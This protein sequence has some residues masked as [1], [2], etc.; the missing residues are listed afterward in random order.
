MGREIKLAESW[1]EATAQRHHYDELQGRLAAD[2]CVIGGG[3][4]GLTTALEC[5]RRGLTTVL[6]EAGRVAGGASG[7]NG[8]FVSNGFAL[9]VEGLIGAVGLAAAKELYTLSRL[10][11]EYVRGTIAAH[12]PAIQMGCGGRVALRHRDTGGLRSYRDLLNG[13]FGEEHQYLSPD[14]TRQFLASTRYFE[15]LASDG[16]FHIHTLHYGIL[17]ARLAQ[18]AG[19]QVFENTSALSCVKEG[20]NFRVTTAT[21]DVYAGQVVH[22][23]SALDSRLHSPS[24]RAVLPVATYVAVTEPLRQ[25][26]IR[27]SSAISDT[28]RAGDYYRLIDEGRILWGGRITTR[29]SEPRHLAEHMKADMLSVYPAL[30]NPRV[31]YAWAGLM[32]YAIHKMPL[33]GRDAEG[34]WFATA[35]GGHGLNTTAMAGVLVARGIS[36]ADDEWRRFSPFAPRWAFGQLGRLGVQGSYWWMQARDRWDEARSPAK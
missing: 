18:D 31:D 36:G 25:D 22:C 4:A 12:D 28:R 19:V 33:I 23:V 16:T 17:L 21:G 7:R 1:Y 8:G 11:T 6:L 10:G 24:G 3:F 20:S 30:G 14:E 29:I 15:S 35:F 32:G 27:T 26:S 2:V 13:E 9:G 5:Q 34:Q